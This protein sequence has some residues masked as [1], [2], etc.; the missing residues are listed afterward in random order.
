MQGRFH[1]FLLTYLI[2]L[3]FSFTLFAQ[4][5]SQLI[6]YSSENSNSQN[7]KEVKIIDSEYILLEALEG[8]D[9]P[10][11]VRKNLEIIT[12]TYYGFDQK[13]HQGQLIVHKRIAKEVIEIFNEIKKIKFPI[14]K[15]IPLTKYNWSDEA[16]MKDNNTSSFNHRYISGTRILSMH[17]KGLAIDINPLQ[18]PYIK[19]DVVSPANAKYDPE[20]KGTIKKDS[21]LTKI[22]K[23]RGWEWGGDWESLKDYQHFHKKLD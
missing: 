7:S 2:T 18:N 16:S 13:L 12:V 3:I 6:K 1:Y 17:A 21:R 22:F 19:N 9:V 20:V 15:V 14:K 4:D 8:I 5:D 10:Y 11:S 23:E